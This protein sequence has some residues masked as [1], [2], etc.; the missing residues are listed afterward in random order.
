MSHTSQLSF[1]IQNHLEKSLKRC[2]LSRGFSMAAELSVSVAARSVAACG[3]SLGRQTVHHGYFI[4]R[5]HQVHS[6]STY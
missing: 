1:A 3:E 6:V 5:R 4:S 2:V